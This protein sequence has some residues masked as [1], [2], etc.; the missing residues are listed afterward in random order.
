M[1]FVCLFYLHDQ[2]MSAGHQGEAIG[3][4]EGFRDVLSEGVSGTS[5]RDPPPTTII[6]VRPQQVAHWALIYRGDLI[7]YSAKHLITFVFYNSNLS[8]FSDPQTAHA[9]L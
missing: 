2:L 6:G 9:Q 8:F 4:V 1:C 7:L 5:R 3:V